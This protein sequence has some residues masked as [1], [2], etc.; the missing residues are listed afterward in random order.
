MED[1]PPNKE[2]KLSLRLGGSDSAKDARNIDS[3]SIKIEQICRERSDLPLYRHLDNSMNTLLF[4]CGLNQRYKDYRNRYCSFLH[5]LWNLV[6]L[7][8]AFVVFF[9]CDFICIITSFLEKTDPFV[10]VFYI[11]LLVQLVS[12]AI[13][14]NYNYRRLLQSDFQLIEL[15]YYGSS[16]DLVCKVF[17]PLMS[18]NFIP[19]I[20]F[21]L[22]HDDYILYP[23]SVAG[24]IAFVIQALLFSVSLIF[25]MVDVSVCKYFL[26]YALKRVSTL[27]DVINIRELEIIRDEINK[28]VANFQ[29]TNNFLM[30]VALCTISYV[31]LALLVSQSLFSS[32]QFLAFL[33]VAMSREFLFL[34]AGFWEVAKVNELSNELIRTLSRLTVPPEDGT[35]RVEVTKLEEGYETISPKEFMIYKLYVNA[36]G[37]PIS[38]R[39]N[40]LRLTRNDILIRLALWLIGIVI[41]IVGQNF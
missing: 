7:S 22:L 26:H 2:S 36:S 34:L 28:R 4:F 27:E 9:I 29:L 18:V 38:F 31:F 10:G 16:L 12:L 1:V 17:L 39:L 19:F 30:A 20:V 11:L 15:N 14:T 8:F 24:C 40:G 13:S 23:V 6:V 25:I 35:D 33:L 37:D 41:G 5:I 21:F 32:Y 3:G